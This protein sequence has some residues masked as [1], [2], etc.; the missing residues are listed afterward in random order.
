MTSST[1]IITKSEA[2]SEAF[3][4]TDERLNDLYMTQIYDAMAKIFYPI[5]YNSVGARHNLMDLIDND[6]AYATKYG[7]SFPRRARPGI[8]ASD[9]NIT[10]DASLDSQKQEAVH[11]A[12]IAYWEIYDVAKS[13]ANR[14]IVRIVTN[15]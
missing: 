11:K 9:I 13:K 5:R 2:A 6:T 14:F 8:Y 10:K 7:E 4:M 15:V 12:T 3:E 1:N